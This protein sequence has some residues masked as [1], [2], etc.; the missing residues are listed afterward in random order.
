MKEMI[1]D[2]CLPR[3]PV[4]LVVGRDEKERA[5]AKVLIEEIE[6]AVIECD[7]AK[8]ALQAID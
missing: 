3:P 2:R 5:M 6:L 8:A 4:A 1:M 7:T